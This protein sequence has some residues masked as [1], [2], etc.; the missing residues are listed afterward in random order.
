MLIGA[1]VLV[2]LMAAPAAAQYPFNVSPGTVVAGAEVTIS[3]K[4][5]APLSTVSV[6][7]TQR[8]TG[9]V[10]LTDSGTTDAQGEFTFNVKIPADA[11]P[12]WYDLEARC[13]IDGSTAADS[14]RDLQGVPEGNDLVFRASIYVEGETPATTTPSK[15]G[16]TTTPI[17]RTGSDLNGLGLAGAGLITVGGIILIATRS[18]RHARA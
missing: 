15:G 3:G 6:K 7:V 8:S 9:T 1:A 11:A 2:A 5:C 16:G 14:G 17:V 4:G 10:I 18:R 12:G 13:P